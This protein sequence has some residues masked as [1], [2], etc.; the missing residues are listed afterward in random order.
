M[1]RGNKNDGSD[2]MD[3][4]R[5]LRLEEYHEVYHGDEDHRVDFKIVV[6]EYVDL[7]NDCQR[8]KGIVDVAGSKFRGLYTNL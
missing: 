4:C 8:L 2:A 3:L 5:L 6:K 7:R 1:S